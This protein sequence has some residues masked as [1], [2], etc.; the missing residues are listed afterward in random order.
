ML[1]DW[2]WF[3]AYFASNRLYFELASKVRNWQWA[4]GTGCDSAPY[5]RALNPYEQLIKFDNKL[6]Y[7]KR[8]VPEFHESTYAQPMVD[9]KTAISCSRNRSNHELRAAVWSLRAASAAARSALRHA[10]TLRAAIAAIAARSNHGLRAAMW[11]LNAAAIANVL[12]DDSHL[13]PQNK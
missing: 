12:G 3:E 4:A 2:R 1:I 6:N 10:A 9:N 5:F 11:S 8:G 7:I 13:R